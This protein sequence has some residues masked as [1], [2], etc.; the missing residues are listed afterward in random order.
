MEKKKIIQNLCINEILFI[1]QNSSEIE[2]HSSEE[3]EE[4]FINFS[5]MLDQPRHQSSNE[6]KFISFLNDKN[7][8][9]SCLNNY[10]K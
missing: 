1:K 2:S 8:S 5:S 3:S 4:S 7:K 6:L 10:Q 9:L